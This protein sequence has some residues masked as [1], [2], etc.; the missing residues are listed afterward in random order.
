MNN[1]GF[2]LLYLDPGTG[3]LIVQFIIAAVTGTIF[4]F[5]NIRE[6]IAYYYHRFF[7]K[8]HQE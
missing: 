3:S 7:R 5:K 1:L 2:I 8:D 4:F 6:K